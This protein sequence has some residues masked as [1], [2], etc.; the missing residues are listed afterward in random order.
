M[1]LTVLPVK[2]DGIESGILADNPPTPVYLHVPRIP[3][4]ASG[5]TQPSAG[6]SH[7]QGGRER[8]LNAIK[9]CHDHTL[10][11][12]SFPSHSGHFLA[13][14]PS[15]DLEHDTQQSVMSL[16]SSGLPL[17]KS[18][19]LQIE[20]LHKCDQVVE[21]TLHEREERGWWALRYQQVLREMQRHTA[22]STINYDS[23]PKYHRALNVAP[24]SQKSSPRTFLSP[25]S[26]GNR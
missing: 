9:Q 14:G 22:M 16:I 12:L 1:E 3:T 5:E 10:R 20:E 26:N 7:A 11:S 21:P 24:C 18:P 8:W 15:V 17:P 6:F 4:G 2:L 23:T 19:S 25:P 13:H